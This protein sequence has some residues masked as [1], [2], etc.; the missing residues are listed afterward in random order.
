MH[1]VRNRPQPPKREETKIEPA[2]PTG[3]VAPPELPKLEAAIPAAAPA[4]KPIVEPTMENKSLQRWLQGWVMDTNGSDLNITSA[5][6][7]PE[8]VERAGG[9]LHIVLTRGGMKLHIIIAGVEDT[10]LVTDARPAET[11]SDATQSL[12]D[13][14]STEAVTE[15]AVTESVV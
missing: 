13:T 2:T 11:V 9:A 1:I 6:K 8:G 15:P 14:V 12:V 5:D 7:K 4:L 3:V 10:A